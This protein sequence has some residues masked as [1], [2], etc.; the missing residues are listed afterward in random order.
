M[1]VDTHFPFTGLTGHV[2][3][4][5]LTFYMRNGTLIARAIGTQKRKRTEDQLIAQ[6]FHTKAGRYYRELTPPQVA[7]WD[8]Y[9]RV[10]HPGTKLTGQLVFLQVQFLRQCLGLSLSADAPSLGPPPGAIAVIAQGCQNSC[11]F[12]YGIR[13]GIQEPAGHF[14]RFDITKAMPSV[15]RTP[16]ATELRMIRH[17]GPDSFL[18]LERTGALYTIENARFAIPTGSRY[19]L[20]VT[21]ITP[22]GVPGP[23]FT[24]DLIR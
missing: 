17:T 1:K 23:A 22:E 14:V 24:A 10:H 12:C 8:A 18:P 20:R 16:R 15:A 4:G 11:E 7:A 5:G 2:K 13:H 19:G 21:L 9:A 3:D 6:D